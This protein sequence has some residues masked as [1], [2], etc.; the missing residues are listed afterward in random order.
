MDKELRIAE[1][2]HAKRK[3]VEVLDLTKAEAV[4]TAVFFRIR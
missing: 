1:L 2:Q 3:Q 4:C